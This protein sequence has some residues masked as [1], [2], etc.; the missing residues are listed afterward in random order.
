MINTSEAIQDLTEDIEKET[1]KLQQLGHSK[2]DKNKRRKIRRRLQIYRKELKSSL[3]SIAN[4]LGISVLFTA[5]SITLCNSCFTACFACSGAALCVNSAIAV[6]SGMTGVLGVV[7]VLG[8]LAIGTKG[9]YKL[10]RPA[11]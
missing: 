1:R 10:I 3:F 11:F 2:D 4:F 5:G 7:A 9:V 6:V 8:L